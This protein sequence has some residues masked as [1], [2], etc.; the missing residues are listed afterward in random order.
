VLHVEDSPLDAELLAESLRSDGIEAELVRVDAREGLAVA[1]DG[2]PP[3]IV[4]A[5][6]RLPGINSLEVIEAVRAAAAD[7]PVVFVSG[8]STRMPRSSC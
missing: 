7:L 8:T 2:A 1:L 5:D 4:I 3:D 6:C